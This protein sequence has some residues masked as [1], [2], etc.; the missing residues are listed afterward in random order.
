MP[1]GQNMDL[2]ILQRPGPHGHNSNEILLW[3][4]CITA[5]SLLTD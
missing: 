3:Y 1:Y 5:M 4:F 2:P